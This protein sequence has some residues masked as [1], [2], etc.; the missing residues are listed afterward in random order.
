MDAG[1]A[2]LR[3]R[4]AH[5]DGPRHGQRWQHLQRK[6]DADDSHGRTGGARPRR[7]E[8]RIRGVR[9]LRDGRV[10]GRRAHARSQLRP[11]H[12]TAGAEGPFGPQ[13]GA[14]VGG[15]QSLLKQPSGSMILTEPSGAQAIFATD[16]KGGFTS[17]NGDSNL[18]LSNTPC[19]AGATELMLTDEATKASVCFVVPSGGNGEIW[20]PH[21]TKTAVVGEMTTYTYRPVEVNNAYNL[22][23]GSDPTTI[24]TGPDGNLWFGDQLSGKIGRITTSGAITEY[25]L[26]SK[27]S[28][29]GIT[30]GPDGNLW[31]TMDSPSK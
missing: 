1:R 15:S 27:G 6:H 28:P 7:G 2:Q 26:P 23:A 17:P 21:L 13:W 10:A 22:P 8:S 30:V 5:A 11:Q 4:A 24:V 25:S 14:S 18:S 19:E 9:P 3:Y 12:L 16:G 20:V 29:V 31:F